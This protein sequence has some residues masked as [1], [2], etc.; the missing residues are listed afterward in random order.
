VSD[1][2]RLLS[3]LC[4]KN[5][6]YMFEL[7]YRCNFHNKTLLSRGFTEGPYLE[8]STK[9]TMC[10]YE[11]IGWLTGHQSFI[12]TNIYGTVALCR[13]RTRKLTPYTRIPRFITTSQIEPTMIG[14]ACRT[15]TR[16]QQLDSASEKTFIVSGR[17]YPLTHPAARKGHNIWQKLFLQ[18]QVFFFE[19][20]IRW[21]IWLLIA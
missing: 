19:W 21:L 5:E 6:E 18:H 16:Y 14:L 9:W 12:V 15:L 17:A 1:G 3:I 20:W 10:W 7:K 13:S 8:V 2:H 4:Y 11:D